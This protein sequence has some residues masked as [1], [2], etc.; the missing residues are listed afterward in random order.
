MNRI[1]LLASLSLALTFCPTTRGASI[2]YILQSYPSQQNGFTLS[3]SITTDG[4]IGVL[5]STDIKAWSYSIYSGGTLLDSESSDRSD[6]P[7]FTVGL[8]A[9]GTSLTLPVPMSGSDYALEFEPVFDD[10]GLFWGR[11][12][13]SNQDTYRVFVDG[14]AELWGTTSSPVGS[15]SLGGTNWIIATIPEPGS[16]SLALLGSACLAVVQWTRRRRRVASSSQA[17]PTANACPSRTSTRR[18]DG[19]S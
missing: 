14:A 19:R 1:L 3:G 12:T 13:S 7:A 2:T 11:D 17:N 18:S 10:R 4:V 8:T 5:Q 16:L 6:F 9:T 15:L